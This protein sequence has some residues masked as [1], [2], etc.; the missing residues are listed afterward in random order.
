MFGPVVCLDGDCPEIAERSGENVA[1]TVTGENAA[2]VIYTSGSTGKPKGVVVS[3]R[4][5]MNYL[6]WVECCLCGRR[7]EWGD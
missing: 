3:H 1:V 4:G 2:Y 7:R 5:L 6:V